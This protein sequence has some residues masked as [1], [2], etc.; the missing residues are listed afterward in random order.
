MDDFYEILGCTTEDSRA[1]LKSC[2]QSLILLTHPDKAPLAPTSTTD[3]ITSPSFHDVTRAWRCLS[4]DAARR[5]YDATRAERDL[6]LLEGPVNDTVDVECF[7]S[8][9]G[10]DSYST[11]CTCGDR[12]TLTTDQRDCRL[13]ILSCDSCSLSI[14]VVYHE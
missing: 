3:A 9:P 10:G 13:D 1:T 5:V 11:E 4:D 8:S 7:D 12:F 14:R 2:Y 6:L